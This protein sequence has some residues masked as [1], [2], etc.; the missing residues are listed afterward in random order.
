MEENEQNNLNK[1]NHKKLKSNSFIKQTQK[2][3]EK[4]YYKSIISTFQ[5]LYI[6]NDHEKKKK[7][8]MITR[9]AIIKKA[10]TKNIIIP[11]SHRHLKAHIAPNHQNYNNFL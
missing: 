8:I 11:S 4:S 2:R 7:T 5:D 1:E 9:I 6:H 10:Y 3:G